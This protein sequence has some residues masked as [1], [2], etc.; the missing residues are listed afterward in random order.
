MTPQHQHRRARLSVASKLI[1]HGHVVDERTVAHVMRRV[2]EERHD[3]ASA[4]LRA[5][6]DV[7]T[8][9]DIQDSFG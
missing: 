2:P 8:T 6:A 9:N 5:A 4:L 3:D 7:R 1:D